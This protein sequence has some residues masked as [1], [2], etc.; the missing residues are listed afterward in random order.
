[1]NNNLSVYADGQAWLVLIAGLSIAI[2]AVLISVKAF[3][4]RER[5]RLSRRAP[6]QDKPE[7]FCGDDCL[8]VKKYQENI[9]E[10]NSEI[11]YWKQAYK[12]AE[13]RCSLMQDTIVKLRKK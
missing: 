9:A 5:K 12:G 13:N 2:G 10:L 4:R 8:L 11:E 3:K 1:M 7:R 6:K